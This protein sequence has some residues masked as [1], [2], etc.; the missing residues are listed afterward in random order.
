MNVRKL[1]KF[2]Y[3]K[4]NKFQYFDLQRREIIRIFLFQSAVLENIFPITLPIGNCILYDV[5]I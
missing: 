3:N 2:I 4:L 1:D 5:A